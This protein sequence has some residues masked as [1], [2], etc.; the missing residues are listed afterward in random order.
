MTNQLIDPLARRSPIDI[1]YRKDP[2]E[3]FLRS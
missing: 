3:H 2:L 1:L